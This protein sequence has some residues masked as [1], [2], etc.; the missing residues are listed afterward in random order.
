MLKSFLN[1]DRDSGEEGMDRDEKTRKGIVIR[2]RCDSCGT[3]ISLIVDEGDACILKC[4]RC[5]REYQFYY[6]A[7]VLLFPASLCDPVRL[8]STIG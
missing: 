8:Q 2:K 4:A 6:N 5:G 3:R 7:A 1:E